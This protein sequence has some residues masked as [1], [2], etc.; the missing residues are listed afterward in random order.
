MTSNLPATVTLYPKK[1][2]AIWLLLCCLTFVVIGVW[3][4]IK[5][6]WIG[7]ACAA[8]FALGIPIAIIQFLPGS[9][10]LKLDE[11][12]LTFCSL[13]RK[14]T[15]PWSVVDDFFVVTLKQSGITV[16]KMVGFNFVPSYDRQRVGRR[17]ASVIGA[18]EGALP[19]TY[20]KKAEE[21]VEL[22]Q[23]YL[24]LARTR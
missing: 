2:S 20:G 5:E 22:L 24:Q 14:T 15:V 13:Y 10:Y 8:F 23:S 7:Y 21:L 1:S 9:A 19:D 4:G 18:C 6:S 16:R 12:G 3:M 17:I 11:T